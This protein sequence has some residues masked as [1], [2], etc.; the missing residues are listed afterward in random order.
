MAR[1]ANL[2][3]QRPMLIRHTV[4]SAEA[5]AGSATL[6]LNTGS[7]PTDPF[8]FIGQVRTSDGVETPGFDWE[9]ITSSGVILLKA[10]G[11]ATLDENG[12]ITI[13][14]TYFA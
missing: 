1:N 5:S 12:S 4:T 14:G 2:T 7:L 9:Y 8:Q 11:T 3:Y 6:E 10:A 13:I